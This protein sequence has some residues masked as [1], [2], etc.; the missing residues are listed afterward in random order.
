MLWKALK[1]ILQIVGYDAVTLEQ[2]LI[3]NNRNK[4]IKQSLPAAWS[5]Y[6]NLQQGGELV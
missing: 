6:A 4:T 2:E 1:D 5:G 3:F